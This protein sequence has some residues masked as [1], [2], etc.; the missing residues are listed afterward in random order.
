MGDG[1][2]VFLDEW[3]SKNMP[4][5]RYIDASKYEIVQERVTPP[6][7]PADIISVNSLLEDTLRQVAPSRTWAREI[8]KPET[9]K[10]III[11]DSKMPVEA[12]NFDADA[13]A[14]PFEVKVAKKRGRPR[15]AK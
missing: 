1:W 5:H 12:P 13:I 15:K 8:L 7:Q 2:A 10:Q 3:F 11:E 9:A 6:R 4:S 14:A